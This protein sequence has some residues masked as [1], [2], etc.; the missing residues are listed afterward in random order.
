MLGDRLR[1][2]TGGDYGRGQARRRRLGGRFRLG[3]LGL[4]GLFGQHGVETLAQLVEFGLQ[5]FEARLHIEEQAVRP[6]RTLL[7]RLGQVLFEVMAEVTQALLP[8]QARAP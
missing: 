5:A 1:Q 6:G 8:G 3:G 2:C 7:L 4:L